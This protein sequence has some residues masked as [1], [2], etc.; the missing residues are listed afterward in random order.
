M[1]EIII[2][3]IKEFRQIS[4]NKQMLGIIFGMPLIQLLILANAAT[5]EMKNINIGILDRDIS[6]V[7]R[8]LVGKFEGS[9]Y[10]KLTDWFESEKEAEISL[11]KGDCD[12]YLT[13]PQG[14]EKDLFK[15]NSAVT[16]FVV[17]AIDGS[18]AALA[19][20]YTSSVITDFNQELREENINH[21]TIAMN[22]NLMKNINIEY[23]NWYNPELN[24]KTF[25]VPGLLVLLV[26]MVSLF[27]SGMNLVREK[28]LGTI[29][30]INVTPIKKYQLILGKLL[31]FWII[32]MFDLGL[33]LVVSKLVY[34]IPI[35]G[36]V[37]L[38][39]AFAGV[40][41]T[42][43]LGIGFLIST[44]TETQQ[45]SMFLTWFFSVIFILLSGLFTAIENMPQWAQT[46]T[47]FNPLRYFM[48]SVRMILL[49]GSGFS[50]ISFNMGMLL[51]YSVVI[52]G[53][54][55]L[56]YKKTS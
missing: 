44:I 16:F 3:L 56:L 31:P 2:I 13:I 38:L 4:R 49:K 25:M 14:F 41:I 39:F 10:F 27:L 48:D 32:G 43:L 15:E 19:S 5:F 34:H 28:E 30:Q 52:N 22:L 37:P 50:D 55:I 17:N 23:S 12:L 42:V 9:R 36:S 6:S 26:S 18:K 11:E 20:Q 46:L 51:V 54:A 33:G 24:Y 8:R 40:F 35:V 1:R 29:E 7:S 53:L 47:Y 21:S 45:Q